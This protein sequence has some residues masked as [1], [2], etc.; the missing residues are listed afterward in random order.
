ML[1]NREGRFQALISDVAV[2]E[3]G[4][5]PKCCVALTYNIVTERT[6]DGWTDVEKEGMSIVGY[7]YIEK[8]DGSINDYTVNNFKDVFMWDG[9]NLDHLLTLKGERSGEGAQVQITLAW[10]EYEG[11]RR[12]RVQFLNKS[13]AEGG[14]VKHDPDA[15]KRAQSRLGS[16][17]RALSGGSSVPATKAAA[18]AA[19]TPPQ[20]SAPVVTTPAPQEGFPW[21][22]SSAD[23]CWSEFTKKFST[24]PT[25]IQGKGWNELIQRVHVGCTDI[26]TLTPEQWGEVWAEMNKPGF[27]IAV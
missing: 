1:P 22:S 15:M 17:L 13:D 4:K 18:P 3:N 26:N 6:A 16:K 23:A 21:E 2:I 5:P 27:K 14:Q 19:S 11:K 10:E 25:A 9:K 20:V 12:L 24:L 7:H 8:S